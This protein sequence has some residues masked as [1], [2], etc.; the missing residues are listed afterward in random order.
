MVIGNLADR[1]SIHRSTVPTIALLKWRQME[2][3]MV[4]CDVLKVHVNE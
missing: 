3:I 4:G 2:L 1:K